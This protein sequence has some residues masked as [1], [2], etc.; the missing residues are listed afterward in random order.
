MPRILNLFVRRRLTLVVRGLAP[1]LLFIVATLRAAAQASAPEVAS[2]TTITNMAQFWRLSPERQRRQCHARMEILVYY[3]DSDWN[4]FWGRS[5]GLDTFLPLRGLPQPLRPGDRILIDGPVLPA[6][7]EFAWDKTTLRILS[8]SNQLAA[9]SARGKLLDIEELKSEFVEIDALVDSCQQLV[10]TILRLN[11][12]AD[13]TY[14]TAWV[15]LDDPTQ[16]VPDLQGKLVRIRG[17]YS[18]TLDPLGKLA[19][20]VLWTPGLSQVET[21][22]SLA[23]DPRF[24]LPVSSSKDLTG[25]DPKALVRVAGVVRSQQSGEAVTIWDDLGQIRVLTKQ[26]QPVHL[27]DWIEAIGYPKIEGYD[28]LLQSGLFRLAE[29]P[30]LEANTNAANGAR[31]HLADQVRSLGLESLASQPAVSLEGEVTWADAQTGFIFIQD[32]SGGIRVQQNRLASGRRIQTGMLLDVDGVAAMGEYAPL[33][34]NAVAHPAGTLDTP[35]APLISLE[36]ALT[37]TE[38][39]HWIQLRGYVRAATNGPQWLT[40]Q[41]VAPGGEFIA[42]VPKEDATLAPPGSAVLIRGVCVARADARRQLTGIEIWT[43]ITDSVQTEQLPPP[44]VFALPPRPIS[45]LR[46]F[47]VFNSLNQRVRTAGTVTLQVPG[48]YLFLQAGVSSLFALSHQTEPLYPGDQVDI[49]GFPGTDRGRF[50]LREAVYRRA[51]RGSEPAPKVLNTLS[52]ASE[53]LDGLLVQTEGTLLDVMT[54]PGETRLVIQGDGRIF[55]AKLEGAAPLAANELAPNSKLAVSGVYR[56]QRDEYGQ[57][58]SFL[59]SLRNRGDI[60]VLQPPPW[61]TLRK[62][63]FFLAGGLPV[64]LL[65][66]F[67]GLQTRRKNQL[68]Q[69][70]Q[71]ELRVAHDRLEERVAERTRE[72]NEEVAAR[73]RALDRLSEA[74]QRLL[75]ASRQAG[76]AEVATGI[77]HNVGNTLNSVNISASVIGDH[78]P[79]LR[80]DSFSQAVALLNAQNGDL[81]TFLAQDPRG[82]A[83]PGYLQKLAAAMRQTEQTLLAEVQSLTKQIDHIKAVVAWQQGFARSS[84][85]YE[86]LNPVDLMEDALLLNQGDYKRHGIEVVREFAAS[87]PITA[88]RHKILQ[89]LINLLANAR[90]SLAASQ[91]AVKRVVLRI[92]LPGDNRVRFEVSDNGIGI[93]PENLELVFSLGFTTKATGHGFGLHSGANGAKEMGGRLFALSDGAGL[94]AT[95]VLELPVAPSTGPSLPSAAGAPIKQPL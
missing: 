6:S 79:R 35:V 41:L 47:D 52:T 90:Q 44:D 8:Q 15:H 62:I 53:D 9:V 66:L 12:V 38:D 21:I 92:Q 26:R 72:L 30:D 54:E 65:A 55:G 69:R 37:G 17:I 80:I 95:F 77:L 82:R 43:T 63:S 18:P 22:G 84:G 56:I 45:S 2:E 74:Q 20:L 24:S 86:T 16:P 73:K 13:N 7:Q 89:I 49:V 27:G 78:L 68:L 33:V 50:L 67:W 59:L 57:P 76:M 14:L 23:D 87:A 31:L 32:S 51:A 11:L 88:D 34:T 61:W 28:R 3:S 64:L 81:G 42:Q 94:G 60:R 48:Q 58:M 71:V 10:P 85:F 4:V 19:L 93:P 1:V 36:Q 46:Q 40:L 70:A 75:L 25:A 83:L 29:K 5:D 91:A 39:G